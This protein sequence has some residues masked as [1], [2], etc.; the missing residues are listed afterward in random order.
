MR[1]SNSH[2]KKSIKSNSVYGQKVWKF[3]KAS[4][5]E[6]VNRNTDIAY[7]DCTRKYTYDQA[8]NEWDRYARAFSGLNIC[9]KNKSRVAVA[10]AI[11]VEPVF[12]Y[13]GLN[14]TGAEVSMFSYPDFLPSG[15]WDVPMD[16]VISA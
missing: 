13:F 7:I 4:T 5:S 12:C 6:Y 8:F 15:K 16:K 1:T 14:M 11:T 10:G 2:T 9:Q 3:I